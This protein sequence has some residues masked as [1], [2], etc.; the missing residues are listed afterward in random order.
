LDD[1]IKT[2]A[3]VREQENL[4][5][6]GTYI[7]ERIVKELGDASAIDAATGGN[8]LAFTKVHTSTHDTAT[9]ITFRQDGRYLYRNGFIIGKNIRKFDAARNPAIPANGSVESITIILTLDSID[10]AK[11][12]ILSLETTVIPNN[13]VSS[14]T[15][16][17]SYNGNYYENIQ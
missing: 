1:A 7:M 8:T 14:S 12:P 15:A 16:R 10:N 13:Y 11:I 2:Y 17:R 3:L 6:D 5:S 4:Y 9:A